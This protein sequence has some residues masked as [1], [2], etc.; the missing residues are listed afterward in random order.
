MSNINTIFH[1]FVLL[2]DILFDLYSMSKI[3]KSFS[4]LYIFGTPCLFHDKKF[5]FGNSQLVRV[6]T[7]GIWL[8]PAGLDR[9]TRWRGG[10]TI[11]GEDVR[12]L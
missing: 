2:K 11:G 10:K 9:M 6:Q 12:K 4:M 1:I 5:S 3:T 8:K 7:A